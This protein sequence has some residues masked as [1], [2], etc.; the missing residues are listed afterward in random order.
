MEELGGDWR[1]RYGSISSSYNIRSSYYLANTYYFICLPSFL[2]EFVIANRIYIITTP[3]SFFS[4]LFFLPVCSRV[5]DLNFPRFI[6]LVMFPAH[7]SMKL[8]LG[9][10]FKIICQSVR[11]VLVLLFLFQIHVMEVTFRERLITRFTGP[12]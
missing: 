2:F 5:L 9:E 12:Q 4:F 6:R 1:D 3:M 7:E 8:G 10:C 11:L